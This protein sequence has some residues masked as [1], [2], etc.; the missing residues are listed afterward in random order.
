MVE[1]TVPEILEVIAFCSSGKFPAILQGVFLEFSSGTPERIPQTAT[2]FSSFLHASMS[3][4]LMAFLAMASLFAFKE[5]LGW[6]KVRAGS[7]QCP[8]FLLWKPIG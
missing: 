8:V 3:D 1:N 2:A 6:S 5:G 7:E 4:F